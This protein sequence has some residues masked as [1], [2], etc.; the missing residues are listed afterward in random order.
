[1]RLRLIEVEVQRA[2]IPKSDIATLPDDLRPS[3]KLHRQAI[4][5]AGAC[6]R[7]IAAIQRQ[8]SRPGTVEKKCASLTHAA[9][10]GVQP[11]QEAHMVRI[12]ITFLLVL[13]VFLTPVASLAAGAQGVVIPEPPICEVP[14][15]V[16]PLIADQVEIRSQRIDV[17]VTDQVA[18]THVTQVFH[19]P[20]DWLAEGTY[21][22]PI[23]PGAAIS[24]FSM[25]VDGEPVAAKL[26]DADEARAIY[27]EIVRKLRD[28]ALLEYIGSGLI[29]A[30]VFPIPAGEDRE[31][32]LEYSEI[33][34]AEQGLNRY[35]YPFNAQPF[36]STPLQNVSIRVAV[37][38]NEPLRA[39]YS[40]SHDIAVDR[41]SDSSFTAGYEASDVI[42]DSDFELFWSVSP[43]DVGANVVS[44]YDASREQG[45]FLLLAAP[46]IER[47]S[48]LVAKDVIVVLDTSGSM[49][50]EKIEQAREALL[51]VLDHLNPE[52]RFNIVEFSTGAREYSRDLI[53]AKEAQEAV[54]WVKRLEATGGTD[55]NLALL[56]ALDMVQPERPTMLLFLTDGVA[57]EGEQDTGYIIDNIAGAAPANVRLF[58]F[59]VGDDVDTIL[60]DT[61][62][63]EQHGR[64]TYV[65]PGQA[66]NEAVSGFYAGITAPVLADVELTVDGVTVDDIYP[67][68]L[69]DLFAG[70][71]LV[72]LGTYREGGDAEIT[73]DGE[74]NGEKTRFTYP[75]SFA[76][77]GGSDF[78]P[79]LWATRKI[80]Y[81]VNEIRLHGEN[82]ELI[83][84]IIDLSLEYGI[85]T[86]YT[87]YLI[88]E[89]D[90]QS[91][92]ARQRAADMAANE[93]AA[94]PAVGSAA[95][96]R[97]Q[98]V[99][100]LADAEQVAPV[101]QATFVAA[102]GE[103]IS[104]AEVLRYAGSNAFVLRD[105][106][107]TD[108]R[109]NEATMS[110]EDVAFA[111]DQYFAL[112]DDH[113]ELAPAFALGQQ[114]IVVIDDSAYRI[115]NAG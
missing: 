107:W 104:A 94:A 48:D 45:Y 25:T 80:G 81:L 42:P 28:P 74:V 23:P 10:S 24:E 108:T 12:P 13:A 63:G 57:T 38:S 73:L 18:T 36:T 26:L 34:P 113:P 79:R 72:A 105:G 89:D 66:L 62:S 99:Q 27:D 21:V 4:E 115:T 69:P 51:Y 41:T 11:V 97:A 7:T 39:V 20:N 58:S 86:P 111:S 78:L 109:Y 46:G 52:D 54:P 88:T 87:S 106:V 49:E 35:R 19:N 91:E 92:G 22:F 70:S 16:P 47:D 6:Q 31:I 65:R 56:N 96:D 100:Q 8:A 82:P 17:D 43:G 33:L 1:M 61:L 84:A 5:D 37:K 110:T 9:A 3:W 114:V 2:R 59:G 40:P 102:S 98:S 67:A 14:C 15:T 95:V 103:E 90:I 76:A 83:D 71:Q 85:V 32:E 50:G 93:I 44:Y 55:I 75:V 30:N 60:L 29:Q 112:L 53:P 64:T 77:S 68:P 101:P